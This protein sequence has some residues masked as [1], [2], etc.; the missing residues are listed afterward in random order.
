[1]NHNSTRTKKKRKSSGYSLF[2]EY[3]FELTVVSIFALGV[4]LLVEKMKIKSYVYRL[5]IAI[6]SA[7]KSIF[8]YIMTTVLKIVSGIETSD[9]VGIILILI[10]AYMVF[11]RT[12]FR[13]FRRYASLSTCPT[14][15]GDLKRTHRTPLQ[16]LIEI[17][18]F[19]KVKHYSC[20]KCDYTGIA[21]GYR[22]K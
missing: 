8:F 22:S 5:I 20:K 14:C 10:A 13:I 2:R 21:I 17:A 4:F 3:R 15:D 9:I 7:I 16:K 6:N 11:I 19:A 12:R 1:M 18:L